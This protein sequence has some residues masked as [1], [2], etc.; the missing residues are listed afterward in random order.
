MSDTAVET[1]P[2]EVG[3]IFCSSWGWDQTN[4]DYYKVVRTTAK[5]AWLVPIG[6]VMVEQVAWLAE[7]V[8]ANAEVVICDKCN[9]GPDGWFHDPERA[10]RDYQGESRY[11]EYVVTPTRHLIQWS[12]YRGHA[13]PSLKVRSFSW[14]HRITGDET[15]YQSHY[16]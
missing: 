5:S 1:R 2:V 11:H 8:K 9:E 7:N 16:A 13:E 15:H 3:D 4:V 10:P 14:A 12:S 6:Q